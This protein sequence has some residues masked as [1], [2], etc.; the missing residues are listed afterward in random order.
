MRTVGVEEELLLVSAETG[1]PVSAA[2]DVLRRVQDAGAAGHDGG[3]LDHEFKQ[4]QIETASAPH[5]SLTDLRADVTAW[6]STAIDAARTV[7]ALVIA[8]GTSPIPSDSVLMPDARYERIADLLAQT[9]RDQLACACHVH[10]FVESDDEGIAVLDRIRE[11]LHVLV[12]LS[13]NSPFWH[14]VDSGYASYRSEVIR[15]WPTA[16]VPEVFGSVAGYQ[17]LVTAMK[18]TRVM[19]DDGMVYFDA[20]L[21]HHYPTVEIRVADVCPDVDDTIL[22]AALCRGLV[23]TAARDW[24]VGAAPRA[25]AASL[26]RLAGWHAARFGLSGDLLDPRTMRPQPAAV[27]VA[28]LVE[29]VRSSLAANGDEESVDRQVGRVLERGTGADRQRAVL[30]R[31]G[32]L[33]DVVTDLARV[34]A[35]GN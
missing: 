3:T 15:R 4:Q 1:Q 5:R 17:A 27:V 12:A 14:G 22:I 13:A 30:S 26:L 24:R 25:T 33:A 9:A 18:D 11:W 31:T 7:D 2:S 34:T 19:L 16:V 10:V 29:H 6:R 8:A 23:D 21:S 20:R 28:A 32:Q 35:G